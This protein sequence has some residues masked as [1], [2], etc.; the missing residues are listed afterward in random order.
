[1]AE[2]CDSCGT[3]SAQRGSRRCRYC[4]LQAP[5]PVELDEASATLAAAKAATR[6][7]FVGEVLINYGLPVLIG[8]FLL[9]AGL[10]HH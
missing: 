7:A 10:T 5:G 3:E 8:V 2:L 1:M 4:A 9:A 6:W